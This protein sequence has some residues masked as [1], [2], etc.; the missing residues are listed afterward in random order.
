M[1]QKTY[2]TILKFGIYAALERVGMRVD[3]GVVDKID[4]ET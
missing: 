1:P 4:T 3:F 2:L